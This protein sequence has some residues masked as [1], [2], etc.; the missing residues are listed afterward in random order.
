MDE[1]KGAFETLFAYLSDMTDADLPV[2][3][4]EDSSDK[5]Q[6]FLVWKAPASGVQVATDSFDFSQD[7]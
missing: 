2:I 7:G 4:V 5:D 6:V 3:D 1:I